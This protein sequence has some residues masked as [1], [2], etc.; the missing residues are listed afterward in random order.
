MALL[1]KK[2]KDF[3]D[4]RED[5]VSRANIYDTFLEIGGKMERGGYSGS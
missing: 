2:S 4:I 3:L 5:S 1:F